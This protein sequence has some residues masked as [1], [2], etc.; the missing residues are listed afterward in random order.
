MSFHS[1]GIDEIYKYLN[2]DNSGLATAESKARLQKYG[3]NKLNEQKKKSNFG[4]FVDQFKDLMIIV[5]LI[6]AVFSFVISFIN[7]EPFTDSIIIIAIV[8]VNAILGFVQELK[9]DK[10]IDSLKKMQV[11]KVR[12]RRDNKIFIIDSQDLVVGD[13]LV[14]EAGDT[15]PADS[16][17]IKAVSLK[18]NES[19]LTGESEPVEKCSD[20]L[21][22]HISFSERVNMIYQG[23][24]VVYGKCEA[25]VC[26]TADNTEFG[27]IANSLSTEEEITPLQKK[28]NG[29][30]KV[31]S[32]IIAFIIL[33][34]F[35]VGIIKDMKFVEVL[36]LAISLAVAAIPEG[37]PA[38]ITIA[39]SLGTTSMAKKNTIVRK[40][41]SVETLGSVDVICSDKTGTITQNR[42]TV[43]EVIFNNR[44]FDVDKE[45]IENSELIIN[46]MVLC[47]NTEVDQENGGELIGDPTIRFVKNAEPISP[48]SK[49]LIKDYIKNKNDP[50]I[51]MVDDVDDKIGKIPFDIFP[52]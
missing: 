18:V 29:I 41:S 25:V 22:E 2:T 23:T 5:L 35:I 17:I 14:L 51:I 42:M 12:V 3:K 4:K 39:L 8:I 43:R 6:A 44:H 11:T 45:P 37:L 50:L 27:Q 26:L 13:I 28:I 36:M 33:I 19:A 49:N 7:K 47:N 21:D 20:T 40:I 34:M 15:V 24:S 38:V 1:L 32:V 9:A 30:S 46:M 52:I 48:N 16:R 10:A 31:I